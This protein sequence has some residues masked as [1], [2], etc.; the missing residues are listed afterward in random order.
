MTTRR[1]LMA[2]FGGCALLLSGVTPA[3]DQSPAEADFFRALQLDRP[4]AVKKALA[5]GVNPN[6]RDLGGEQ[7]AVH[8]KKNCS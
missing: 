1:L 5:A 6:A 8:V 3:A 4:A 7:S 2:A